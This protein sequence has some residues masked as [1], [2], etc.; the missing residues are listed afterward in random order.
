LGSRALTSGAWP[1]RRTWARSATLFST[2]WVTVRGRGTTR[3]AGP[4]ARRSPRT[5]SSGSLSAGRT[6]LSGTAAHTA[7]HDRVARQALR[8]SQRPLPPR[9]GADRHHPCSDRRATV[10]VHPEPSALHWA[11]ARLAE[12]WHAVGSGHTGLS[13]GF[14][15]YFY[16]KPPGH[17]PAVVPSAFLRPTG[18]SSPPFPPAPLLRQTDGILPPDRLVSVGA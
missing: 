5:S 15:A 8:A 6:S 1:A 3:I 14:R 9:N 16:W 12:G 13:G 2:P 11:N 10:A 17:S 4:G 7:V 18:R